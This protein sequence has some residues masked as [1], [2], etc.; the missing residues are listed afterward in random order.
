MQM[1]PLPA[2]VIPTILNCRELFFLGG[3]GI[4]PSTGGPDG[5]VTQLKLG[6]RRGGEYLLRNWLENKII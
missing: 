5:A 3:T 2:H 6:G 1:L 4:P